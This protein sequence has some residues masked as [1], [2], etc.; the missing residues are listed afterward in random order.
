MSPHPSQSPQPSMPASPAAGHM[1]GAAPPGAGPAG[2]Q[3]TGPRTMGMVSFKTF[4]VCHLY[5]H[6]GVY[7]IKNTMVVGEGIKNEELQRGK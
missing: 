1:T 7:I 6:S 2:F 3:P 4:L 5:R